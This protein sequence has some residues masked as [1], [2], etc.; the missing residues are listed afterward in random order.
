MRSE[1]LQSHFLEILAGIVS[2]HTLELVDETEISL[3]DKDMFKLWNLLGEELGIDLAI[4]TQEQR[5]LLFEACEGGKKISPKHFSSLLWL[6]Y[7]AE[8]PMQ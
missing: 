5:Q 1:Q 8:T 7:Y 3:S 4:A 6:V 2:Q